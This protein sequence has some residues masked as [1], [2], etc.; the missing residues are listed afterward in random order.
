[1]GLVVV[2]A[3]VVRADLQPEGCQ[4]LVL[5]EALAGMVEVKEKHIPE[6]LQQQMLLKIVPLGRDN[7]ISIASLS[8]FFVLLQTGFF[9]FFSFILSFLQLR[10]T[11]IL[12]FI[13]VPLQIV[14]N[15]FLPVFPSKF[16]ITICSLLLTI[17]VCDKCHR[18]IS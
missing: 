5:L 4:L 12:F 10:L 18:S 6:A 7:D 2:A 11:V 13:N 17:E 1:V 9:F 14:C 8:F 16:A 15:A 3:A